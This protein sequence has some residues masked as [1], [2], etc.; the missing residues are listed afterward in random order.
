[1]KIAYSPQVG[2]TLPAKANAGSQLFHKMLYRKNNGWESRKWRKWRG[3]LDRPLEILLLYFLLWRLLF[4][5][6][7]AHYRSHSIF[8][9]CLYPWLSL[10][11]HE[12]SSN[13]EFQQACFWIL[14][15]IRLKLANST[16]STVMN[17]IPS[18]SFLNPTWMVWM[19]TSEISNWI[20]W[21][22]VK[23]KSNYANFH[24]SNLLD[25]C[26]LLLVLSKH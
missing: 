18:S 26:L 15:L 5:N 13:L 4:Y 23:Q 6:G 16:D 20:K 9:S 7:S 3:K 2:K 25:S 11:L 22:A 19:L 12:L 24:I 1:M 10:A 14:M 8:P 21:L 17:C